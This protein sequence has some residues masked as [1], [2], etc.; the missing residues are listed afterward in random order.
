[1]GRWKQTLKLHVIK[2]VKAKGSQQRI[3]AR[4]GKEGF[5]SRAFGGMARLTMILD[6]KTPEL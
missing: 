4:R 6:F 5:F 3:E 2:P 1:M